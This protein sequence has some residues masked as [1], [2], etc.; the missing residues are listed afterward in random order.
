MFNT[1]PNNLKKI[2]SVLEKY[3]LQDLIIGGIN[4]GDEEGLKKISIVIKTLLGKDS[5]VINEILN[6]MVISDSKVD[7]QEDFQ[8]NEI[9]KLFKDFFSFM[10]EI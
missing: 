9:I 8:M 5:N 7:Y 6:L 10:S 4:L 3:D 1:K 2:Y